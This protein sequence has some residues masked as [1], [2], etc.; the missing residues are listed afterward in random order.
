MSSDNTARFRTDQQEENIKVSSTDMVNIMVV[1]SVDMAPMRSNSMDVINERIIHNCSDLEVYTYH[2]PAMTV[3]THS[4]SIDPDITA[5]LRV[6][7]KKRRLVRRRFSASSA[8]DE[9]KDLTV[10]FRSVE[11]REYPIR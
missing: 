3:K 9:V 6:E 1:R 2:Q 4:D 10:C 11:I 5:S 8:G 7:S